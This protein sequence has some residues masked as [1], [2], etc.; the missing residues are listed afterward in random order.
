[1]VSHSLSWYAGQRMNAGITRLDVMAINLSGASL[2]DAGFIA[3]IKT[4]MEKH[5][6]PAGVICFEVTETAAIANLDAATG[7][8]HELKQLGCRFSLDDFGTGL[9]SFAYLKNLPV[10][11]VKIDGSFVRN[12]EAD[13]IDCAMVS[14]IQQLAAV[15]GI[16]T[17]AEFVEND[18]I[19]AKLAEIGVDYAQGYGISKPI[20]LLEFDIGSMRSA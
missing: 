4:E 10:D 11:Y 8:I 2:S 16:K 12:M 18:G 9:S 14:S 15:I 17:V 19:L 20:P 3:H 13:A 7:F 5:E 1:V 6:V